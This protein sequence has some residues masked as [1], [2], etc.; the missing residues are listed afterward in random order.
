MAAQRYFTFTRE[1]TTAD[2]V[3]YFIPC[4]SPTMC[5]ADARGIPNEF[6]ENTEQEVPTVHTKT[7]KKVKVLTLSN[8]Q[9]V[10]KEGLTIPVLHDSLVEPVMDDIFEWNNATEKY[11]WKCKEIIMR[12]AIQDC[13]GRAF[14]N[15][16]DYTNNKVNPQYPRHGIDANRDIR[17]SLQST[18]MFEAFIKNLLTSV[19]AENIKVIM[20]HG[21]DT[22][23][24]VYG[25]YEV[26]SVS[27]AKMTDDGKY[28]ARALWEYLYVA[29]NRINNFYSNTGTDP[30]A[31]TGEWNQ[32]LY[33]ET[34]GILSV[35][36]ELPNSFDEGRRGGSPSY[37]AEKVR[38]TFEGILTGGKGN[39]YELLKDY[40]EIIDGYK[41]THSEEK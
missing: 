33:K 31:Y 12:T 20:M 15:M 24:T 2:T 17:K 7:S 25:T 27:E 11:E 29:E 23:G 19:R 4:L 37:H 3:L 34:C 32:L 8:N 6:W 16:E 41:K 10:L 35:D 14:E 40:N 28:F 9:A 18:R 30:L 22:E 39:Y 5:F 36:I 13:N 26:K 38:E 21:Y 1:G